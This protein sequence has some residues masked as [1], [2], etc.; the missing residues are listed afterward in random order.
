MLTA[1]QAVCHKVPDKQNLSAQ[2]A[3]LLYHAHR[4]RSTL[5]F[6]KEGFFPLSQRPC[7]EIL[8]IISSVPSALR[9][10]VFKI[11]FHRHEPSLRHFCRAVIFHEI[12][13]LF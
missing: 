5:T 4:M 7:A 13:E 1:E 6:R 12:K 10:Q 2:S 11:P 8:S 9:E 3:V